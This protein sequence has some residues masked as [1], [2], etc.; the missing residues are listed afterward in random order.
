MRKIGLGLVVAAFVAAGCGDNMGTDDMAVTDMGVGNDLT[1]NR[2]DMTVPVVLNGTKVVSGAS[3]FITVNKDNYILYFGGSGGINVVKLDGTGQKQAIPSA[4]WVSPWRKVVFGWVLANS[5][6]TTGTLFA[7][8]DGEANARQVAT[9]SVHPSSDKTLSGASASDDGAKI[10]FAR[11]SAAN[12]TTTDIVYANYDGSGEQVV[13]AGVPLDGACELSMGFT[14]G[15][16]FVGYCTGMPAM[17]GGVASATVIA[18]DASTG[19]KTTLFTNAR[20]FFSVDTNATKAFGISTSQQPMW[21]ATT[22]G[23]PTM[24]TSDTVRGE[25]GLMNAAGNNIVWVTESKKLMRLD[26]SAGGLTPVELTTGVERL[27]SISPDYARAFIAKTVDTQAGATDVILTSLTTA[28]QLTTLVNTPTGA[29]YGDAFSKDSAFG[30]YYTDV[31]DGV[32]TLHTRNLTS[33]ADVTIA[34]NVWLEFAGMGNKV[35]FTDNY[36][37]TTTSA[38]VKVV[39]V[40]GGTPT[41]AATQADDSPYV[42]EDGTKIVYTY[43]GRPAA[44]QGMYVYTIP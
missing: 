4:S 15:K 37:D 44:S 11:A 19:A 17:D 16:F 21:I 24:I 22:G 7:W 14:G 26:V 36:K 29:I 2:P 27:L 33:S 34:M 28:G 41:L 43:S 23:S 31:A 38:D 10:L 18:V 13:Q 20:N 1:S 25:L 42:T 6:D 12:A 40:T 5:A 30:F 8:K 9:N 35:V 32:G 3:Q 39:D